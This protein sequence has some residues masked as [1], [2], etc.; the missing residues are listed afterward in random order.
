MEPTRLNQIP[1]FFEEK[2]QN[3]QSDSDI[4]FQKIFENF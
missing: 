3:C 2:I 1:R 4:P